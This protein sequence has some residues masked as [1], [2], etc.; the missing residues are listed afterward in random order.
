MYIK[1]TVEN[2]CGCSLSRVVVVAAPT[3]LENKHVARFQG[4]RVVMAAA[5]SDHPRKRA[6]AF[7]FEVMW[8]QI[9]TALET[10]NGLVFERGGWWWWQSTPATCR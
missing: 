5:Q 6:D 3:A 8:W 9:A 10:S 7:V 4:R 1:T 2:D